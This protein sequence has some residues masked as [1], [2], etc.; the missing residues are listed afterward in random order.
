MGCQYDIQWKSM[1]LQVKEYS[2]FHLSI[3]L[4]GVNLTLPDM[5]RSTHM[6]HSHQMPMSIW[7]HGTV[8]YAR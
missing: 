3:L 2:I 7:K 6:K 8:P 5:I 4:R 1:I